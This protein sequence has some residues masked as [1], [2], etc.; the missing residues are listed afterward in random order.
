MVKLTMA[1]IDGIAG[2]LQ[3]F[4]E[5]EKGLAEKSAV[6]SQGSASASVQFDFQMVHARAHSERAATAS[7]RGLSFAR[8][9]SLPAAAVKGS[10]QTSDDQMRLPS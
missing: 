7:Q 8:V 6:V 4:Q 5:L 3:I 9:C 2:C 10:I 1:E